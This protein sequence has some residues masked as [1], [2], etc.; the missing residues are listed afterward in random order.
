VLNS[1]AERGRF[2]DRGVVMQNKKLWI[3]AAISISLAF[4]LR[5]IIPANH[6]LPGGWPLGSH[7][8]RTDWVTFWVFLMAGVMVGAAAV[9]R[10]TLMPRGYRI[11]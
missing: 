10:L 1:D 8:Y 5:A 11:H 3:L 6:F 4:V 9:L 2:P 7:W